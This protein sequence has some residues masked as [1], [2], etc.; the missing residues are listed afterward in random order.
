MAPNN[1]KVFTYLQALTC[2]VSSS[3]KSSPTHPPIQPVA[4][5]GHSGYQNIF[6]HSRCG[7]R[8][9]KSCKIQPYTT[10]PIAPTTTTA[11]PPSTTTV[12]SPK[13]PRLA[14]YAGC[15]TGYYQR[16]HSVSLLPRA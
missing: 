1:Q 8:L 5:G 12:P 11:A 13:C 6:F 16:P 14:H 7:I 9:A 15:R 2:V 3:L 10:T 4:P